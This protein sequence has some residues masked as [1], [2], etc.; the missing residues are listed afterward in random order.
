M[1]LR[2]GEVYVRWVISKISWYSSRGAVFLITT[3]NVENPTAEALSVERQM[4]MPRDTYSVHTYEGIL[5]P[6][7]ATHT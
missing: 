7:M 6:Q 5:S 2:P 1:A 4:F 3:V